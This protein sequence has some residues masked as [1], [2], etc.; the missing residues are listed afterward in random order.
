YYQN[1]ILFSV[2]T[3][4]TGVAIGT[5]QQY[6][7]AAIEETPPNMHAKA[8]G[9]VMS[10]GI[11]AA[12]IGPTLAVVTRQFFANYPFIGPFLSLTV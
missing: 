8:I 5:A 7:F 2:G 12:I 10:G 1:L 6:R 4:F 3:L 9:L 11:I